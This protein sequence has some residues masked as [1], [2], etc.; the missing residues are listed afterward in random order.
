[1]KFATY[2]AVVLAL[3]LAQDAQAVK[4]RCPDDSNKLKSVLRAL[5]DSPSAS[6]STGCGCGGAPNCSC[7]GAKSSSSTKD[8]VKKAVGKLEKHLDKKAEAKEN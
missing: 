1:M 5:A 6:A 2:S 4:L 7:G 8:E 3:F